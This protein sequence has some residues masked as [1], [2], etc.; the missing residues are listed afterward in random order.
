MTSRIETRSFRW[1]TLD[2]KTFFDEHGYVIVDGVLADE[3]LQRVEEGWGAVVAEAARRAELLPAEF[4]ER[5]PQNRDLWR[6]N[7]LFRSLLFDTDQSAVMRHFLG[8]TGVRLFHDQAICKPRDRSGTIPWH[9]DSAYWLSIGSAHRCGHRPPM[10]LQT[11][12]V[13]RCWIARIT[14]VLVRR[15]TSSPLTARNMMR[16]SATSISQYGADSPWCSMG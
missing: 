10:L 7:D 5:F 9:Q 3:H 15:K 12:G 13:S 16:M 14:M 8:T 6:K 4:I 2:A 11:A 1:D